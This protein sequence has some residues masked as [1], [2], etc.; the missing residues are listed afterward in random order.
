MIPSQYIGDGMEIIDATKENIFSAKI[1][2][3][4]PVIAYQ[5]GIF[6]NNATSDL[7][8]DSGIVKLDKPCYGAD[9]NGN[10][11]PFEYVI[12]PCAD[13]MDNYTVGATY[14]SETG[15]CTLNYDSFTYEPNAIVGFKVP[16]KIGD[17]SFVSVIINNKSYAVN[18][19]DSG[20]VDWNAGDVVFLQLNESDLTATPTNDVKYTMIENGYIYG[21]KYVLTLWWDLNENDYSKGCIDSFETVFWAKSTPTLTINV[22]Y[23]TTDDNGMPVI[24]IKVCDWGATYSHQSNVGVAWF[25]WIL[26]EAADHTRIIDDTGRIYTNSPIAYEFS[27]LSTGQ[28]YSICVNLQTQDGVT[29]TSDWV[30]F[31]VDYEVVEIKSAVVVS[32]TDYDGIKV[33]WGN[34]KYVSGNPNNDNYRYL[35]QLPIEG[36]TCVELLSGNN[37][38]FTSSEHFD[39][40]IPIKQNMYGLD[41]CVKTVMKFITQKV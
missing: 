24:T 35:K 18:I 5:C 23:E 20:V 36:H 15:E 32:H 19:T 3:R 9:S 1:S 34:L 29:I 33:D 22:F 37:I 10:I 41:I 16:E 12:P 27:G 28:T 38:T 30:D 13:S 14:N 40:D 7:V 26:S 31:T 17:A 39:V 2:G 6:K 11:V 25:Q 4:A 8:Y 21:Y